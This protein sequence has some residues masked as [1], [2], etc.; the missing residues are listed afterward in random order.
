MFLLYCANTPCRPTYPTISASLNHSWSMIHL[1]V[2]LISDRGYFTFLYRYTKHNWEGERKE[3]LNK[4]GL[5][6]APSTRRKKSMI[7]FLCILWA[8]TGVYSS[9]NSHKA[10]SNADIFSALLSY[11]LTGLCWLSLLLFFFT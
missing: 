6:S 4:H 7:H 8:N 1:V 2:F 5:G 10:T 3:Q 11:L 9:K